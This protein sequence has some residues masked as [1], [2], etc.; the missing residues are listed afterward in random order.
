MSR[1][2]R[3]GTRR[4][5]PIVNRRSASAYAT[6]AAGSRPPVAPL[7]YGNWIG[8][9]FAE[10]LQQ[11]ELGVLSSAPYNEMYLGEGAA[12]SHYLRYA[13]WLQEQPAER[14]AQKRAEADALFHRV[15]IT[16]AVYGEEAGTERLIPFDIVPRIIP[17]ERM[18]RARRRAQAARAGAERLHPRHLPRPAN[19]ARPASSPPSRC[20]ATRSTARRCRASMCPAAST[21]TSP[22][23][24]SCATMPASSACSRT[25]CACPRASPTC[26]RTAR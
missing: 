15:G 6:G 14:L 2:G 5:E 18:E 11:G 25:T 26:S 10:G 12:R 9:E 21:R 17:A 8:M 3:A 13:E 4:H 24:T 19:P 20:S 22:A 7:P 16:F 1:N 23:S